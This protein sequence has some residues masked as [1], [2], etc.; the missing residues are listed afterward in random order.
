MRI[1]PM[2]WNSSACKACLTVLVSQIASDWS[3]PEQDRFMVAFLG[4]QSIR[5]GDAVVMNISPLL[6]RDTQLA[7]GDVMTNPFVCVSRSVPETQDAK[8]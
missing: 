1:N 2:R 4:F 5:K 3:E 6:G 8:Q 7:L